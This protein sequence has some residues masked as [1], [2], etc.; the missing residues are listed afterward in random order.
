[1]DEWNSQLPDPGNTRGFLTLYKKALHMYWVMKHLLARAMEQVA[2]EM[3][4]LAQGMPDIKK[5]MISLK[6]MIRQQDIK[7]EEMRGMLNELLK[8]KQD[9]GI[10]LE[11]MAD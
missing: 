1:M 4:E 2:V 3:T 5:E 8:A 11:N 6:F 7:L 9:E 10:K